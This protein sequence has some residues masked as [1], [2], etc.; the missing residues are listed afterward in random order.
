MISAGKSGILGLGGEPAIIE[1][2]TSKK[3]KVSTAKTKAAPI[4]GSSA[5]RTSSKPEDSKSFDKSMDIVDEETEK[6]AVDVVNYIL[7]SLQVDVKTFFRD[8]DEKDVK[9]VYF[10]IEGDDSG[11]II[12]RK[13][14]TLR[15]LEFIISFILKRQLD[16]RVRVILDV[17]GYQERRRENLASQAEFT[18]DKVIKT[19]RSMKMDPM[20]PFDRRIVHLTLENEKKVMTESEGV[21]SRRQV[22]IRPK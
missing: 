17:E 14:E 20:S 8:Q 6:L 3:Q 12:G 21:G 11:L 18:A 1:V 7:S 16:K 13:G 9:S 4:K 15:S 2:T 5:R 19:G 10:E 22:V